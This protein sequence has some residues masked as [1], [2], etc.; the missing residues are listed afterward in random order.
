MNE[1]GRGAMQLVA[2]L[3]EN[4]VYHHR[5]TWGA[6]QVP[7]RLHHL[8]VSPP[9]AE[10]LKSAVKCIMMQYGAVKCSKLL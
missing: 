10:N 3:G 6:D 9:P 8:L 4:G 1:A 2:L 5:H 7:T